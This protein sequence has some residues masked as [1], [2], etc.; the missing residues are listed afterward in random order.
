MIKGWEEFEKMRPVT[1][2][3][4]FVAMW[5]NPEMKQFY[6]AGFDPAITTAGDLLPPDWSIWYESHSRPPGQE[7]FR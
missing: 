3:Q 6:D 7:D 2:A 1:S 4:G 5:F